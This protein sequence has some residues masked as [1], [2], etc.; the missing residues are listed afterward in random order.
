MSIIC[1][2]IKR[3]NAGIVLFIQDQGRIAKNELNDINVATRA[4]Q[5][6]WCNPIICYFKV[7]VD[8]V[9][10]R[11]VN[12]I[13]LKFLIKIIVDLLPNIIKLLIKTFFA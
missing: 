11:S 13:S 9:L 5:H 3:I 4:G 1:A 10:L 2:N 7:Y 6:E 8:R 12:H